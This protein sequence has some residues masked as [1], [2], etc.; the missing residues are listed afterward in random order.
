MDNLFSLNNSFRLFD[1]LG[2]EAAII[3]ESK[4]I[5]NEMKQIFQ[6]GMN[7]IKE[8]WQQLVDK[9]PKVKSCVVLNNSP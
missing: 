6:Y 9:Q 4:K 3:F 5:K 8:F 2:M 1:V 7:G